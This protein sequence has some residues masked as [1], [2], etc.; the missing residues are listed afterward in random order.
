MKTFFLSFILS[1]TCL[2]GGAQGRQTA[3]FVSSDGSWQYFPAL[4][5]LPTDYNTTSAKYPMLIF[6]QGIGEAGNI[7]GTQLGNIYNSSTAG[8]PAYFI[9]HPGFPDSFA[10][11]VTGQYYKF[12]ILSPQAP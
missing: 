11:P 4:L 10:H 7:N 5:Q 2:I 1:F 6:L 12:I 9:A 8:G 3:I